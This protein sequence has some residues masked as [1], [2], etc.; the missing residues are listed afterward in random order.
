MELKDLLKLSLPLLILCG[1]GEIFAGGLFGGMSEFLLEHP[2]IIVLIPALIGLKGNIDITL[3]SRLGSAIHLGLIS[4]GNVWNNEMRQNV[5]AAFALTAIMTVI[6]SVLA[7]T[8]SF[9]LGFDS[10][11]LIQLLLIGFSAGVVSGL[12][13]IFITIGIIFFS[14]KFELD[15]DNITAPSLATLGDMITIA[16][17]FIFAF[18]FLEV[19]SL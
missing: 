3:G 9:L 6:A 1:I 17:I 2:G 16:N 13:L 12:I 11:G 14:V 8:T 10:I 15:P 7:Y 19:L 5:G 4:P 18:I